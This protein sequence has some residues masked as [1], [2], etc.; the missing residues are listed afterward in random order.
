MK[1]KERDFTLELKEK[2]QCMEK[3]IERISLKLF[4]E[5]AHLHIEKSMELDIV[6]EREKEDSFETGYYSSVSMAIVDEEGEM[7]D[8]YIIPIWKCENILLGML[9]QSRIWGS[10]KV[11]KLVDYS[12][13]EI[14]EELKEQLEE[15]LE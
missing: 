2:I 5:Y 11:G 3:E 1:Y 6:F 4:R 9:T 14:E 12:Y 13:Y 15:C 10:K 8:F 7:I